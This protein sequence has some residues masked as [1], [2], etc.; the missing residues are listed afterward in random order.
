MICPNC[1][2]DIG[3]NTKW[4][5]WCGSLLDSSEDAF[6]L[7]EA[8]PEARVPKTEGRPKSRQQEPQRGRGG[9]IAFWIALSLILLALIAALCVW[10]IPS[11]NPLKR[12]KPQPATVGGSNAPAA[13]QQERPIGESAAAPTASYE[14]DP[15][16]NPPVSAAAADAWDKVYQFFVLN[17]FAVGGDYDSGVSGEKN[18]AVNGVP[19]FR[20][21]Y[22]EPKF[23]LYDMDDNG[24]PELIIY[25]GAS[26]LA[27]GLDHVFTCENGQILYLGK[28]GFRGCKLYCC[29]GSSL[30]GLFCTD[31]NNGVFRTEHYALQNGSIVS[32]ELIAAPDGTPDALRFFTVDEIRAMGWDSFLEAVST[33]D[34]MQIPQSAPAPVQRTE[35][36]MDAGLQYTA[37][38]FLSNFSEQ[39][40][41]ERN[42]FDVSSPRYEELIQ[43]VY[44]YCKINRHGAL[45][46]DRTQ[47]GSFYTVSLDTVN[48]VL[49]RH[50]GITLTRDQAS[51][52]GNY[53]NG[54]FYY[55]AADG[56]SYNRLTVV[57][58]MESL[59]DGTFELQ[60]DIY[61]LN[62]DVYYANNG[63]V[64]AGYYYTSASAA[65]ADANL[66]WKAAGTALVRPYNHDGYQTMQLI[67]YTVY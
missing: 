2:R 33:R 22:A 51:R 17:Q 58:R 54:S 4:C 53:R 60:F 15:T 25:N 47:E 37:N 59:G 44:L 63:A 29:E 18:F 64:D 5:C 39:N 43:F 61:S 3:N 11:L 42:G 62:L 31:G 55:I 1:K 49:N 20:G 6:A 40:A 36:A 56:E 28:I 38:I 8:E 52:I 27:A 24:V 65:R 41:F 26:A 67:R 21:P 7:S 45:G 48:D 35:I 12:E 14:A 23:S 32:E 10:F 34:P 9:R 46:V 30:P 57:N 16:F 66:T 13:V 19:F 50:F